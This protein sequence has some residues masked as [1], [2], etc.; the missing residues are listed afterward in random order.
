MYLTEEFTLQSATDTEKNIKK[1]K[2]IFQ[3]L[4]KNA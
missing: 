4:V 1:N 3:K 2:K